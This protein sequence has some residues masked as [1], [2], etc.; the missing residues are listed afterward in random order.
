MGKR[1]GEARGEG[2]GGEGGGQGQGGME[3]GKGEGGRVR[4]ISL[5]SL[6]CSLTLLGPWDPIA[7]QPAPFHVQIATSNSSIREAI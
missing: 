1:E 2:G 4:G 5:G 7:Q 6:D 3:G